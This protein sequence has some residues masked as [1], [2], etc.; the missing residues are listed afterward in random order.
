M[1]AARKLLGVVVGSADP[2]Q[3][4]H[5]LQQGA[6]VA[7]MVEDLGKFDTCLVEVNSK[8]P[9]MLHREGDKASIDK[10]KFTSVVKKKRLRPEVVL[11]L[12]EGRLGESGELQAYFD[13]LGIPFSF[14]GVEETRTT[15][16]KA[17]C[18]AVL[19][20]EGLPVVRSILV[21]SAKAV[22]E[23][24][25][26]GA[27]RL[28]GFPLVVKPNRG[29]GSLGVSRVN[30][31]AELK[32]GLETALRHDSQAVVERCVAGGVEVTC[33]V[34]DITQDE[35]LEAFPV[36]E[37]TPE[38]EVFHSSNYTSKTAISTPSKT[39]RGEVILQVTK[40]AKVAYRALNLCGIATFDM[41]VQ[42]D[43]P[44]LL[45][46]NSV[47]PLGPDSLVL[48]QV[49]AGLSCLWQ[50]N[51]AKFYTVVAEHGVKM[52]PVIQTK[53]KAVGARGI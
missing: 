9:W 2:V 48:R 26:R 3:H 31:S 53:K 21:E 17:D 44:V 18:S 32:A 8:G 33:T 15:F 36:T 16:S 1:L 34:H 12:T 28:L 50:R 51:I 24:T 47:P 23:E 20:E 37:I 27:G 5:S 38:G 49:R 7:E 35:L 52:F 11:I 25:I 22:T 40:V 42:D 45:E 41:I 43:L 10:E 4:Q 29:S 19:R 46:V 6:L 39:L 14:S 13:K 30:S